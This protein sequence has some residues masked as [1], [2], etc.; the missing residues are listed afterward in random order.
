MYVKCVTSKPIIMNLKY[1]YQDCKQVRKAMI[2]KGSY[3]IFGVRIGFELKKYLSKNK[4]ENPTNKILHHER[5]RFPI[6]T[7]T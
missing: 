4:Q 2:C 1:Q 5:F 3:G 6:K 7:L